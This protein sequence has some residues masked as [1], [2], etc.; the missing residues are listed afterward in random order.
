MTVYMTGW[1]IAG[2]PMHGR[3]RFDAEPSKADGSADWGAD[4]R[5]APAP[6]MGGGFGGGGGGGGFGGGGGGGGFGGGGSRADE[7]GAWGRGGGGGGGGMPQRRNGF[8]GSGM[9]RADAEDTW[10]RGTAIQHGSPR[11][12]GGGGGGGFG[13]SRADEE[14]RWARGTAMVQQAASPARGGF[15]TSRADDE[16][17]WTRGTALPPSNAA[18]EDIGGPG[19]QSRA[20]TVSSWAKDPHASRGPGPA[21]T[22]TS[23]VAAAD[24]TDDWSRSKVKAT[25]SSAGHSVNSP[26]S[27]RCAVCPFLSPCASNLPVSSCNATNTAD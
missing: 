16:S 1:I 26:R 25:S 24:M 20:D 23:Q 14:P 17:K 12:M 13:S 15:G 5:S 27:D 8:G 21:I 7:E 11:G 10:S 2:A 19:G 22:G 18:R 4:R 9:A 3:T 6:R